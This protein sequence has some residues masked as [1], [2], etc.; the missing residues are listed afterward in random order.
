MDFLVPLLAQLTNGLII[1]FIYALMALGLTLIFGVLKVINFAHG[2]FYMLG[3]YISYIAS[4]MLGLHP[5]IGIIAAVAVVFIIGMLM[6]KALLTPIYEDKVERKDEYALLITFGLSIFLMNGALVVFGPYQK[7]PEPLASGVLD[8]GVLSVS[9][10]RIYAVVLAIIFMAA[11][12]FIINK[13]W[14]GTALRALSQD[15]DAST[16]MGINAKTLGSIAFGL[17]A[18]M[19]GAAGALLAPVFLVFPIMGVVP[20]IKS[21]VIIILGSM[22]SIKGAIYG[23]LLLGIVES[24]GVFFLSPSY[25]DGYSFLL[26]IIILLVKPKG[27]FGGSQWNN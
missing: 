2:E 14:L 16:I 20:A 6:E 5:I 13:T 22:G 19:A 12:L 1:G 8:L 10:G 26:L 24:L 15:R 27:L 3:A 11:T 4:R 25:R 9:S 18:A 17:G 7:S 23:S 21:F